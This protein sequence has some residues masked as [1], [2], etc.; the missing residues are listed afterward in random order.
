MQVSPCVLI[1]E[2]EILLAM[3]LEETM[4]ALGFHISGLAP[5]PD[6][7]RSLAQSEAPDL[8]LMD[9]NLQGGREGIEVARWMRDVCGSE[10][11]FVTGHTDHDTLA[12]IRERVPGAPIL[13]KPVSHK[14][15]EE[16]VT[17]LL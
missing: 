1:V 8:V 6:R 4:S 14:R 15:L 5:T 13:S 17:A 12:R 11:V 2:D 3:D 10:V 7:A 16:T 9:I